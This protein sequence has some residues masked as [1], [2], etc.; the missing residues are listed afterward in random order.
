MNQEDAEDAKKGEKC[1]DHLADSYTVLSNT[2]PMAMHMLISNASFQLQWHEARLHCV[3]SKWH[4]VLLCNQHVWNSECWVNLGE[5]NKVD[6][7]CQ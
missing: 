4:L 2:D 7:S 6:K 1:P 3:D 5:M